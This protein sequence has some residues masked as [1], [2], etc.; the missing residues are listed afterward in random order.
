MEAVFTCADTWLKLPDMEERKRNGQWIS[1]GHELAI[2][3]ACFSIGSRHAIYISI[4]SGFFSSA[5]FRGSVIVSIPS[6]FSAVIA[7]LSTDGASCR[8]EVQD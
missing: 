6:R 3:L 2:P 1:T 8:A 7:A 5:F 4:W